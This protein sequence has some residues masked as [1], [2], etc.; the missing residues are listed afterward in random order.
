MRLAIFEDRSALQFAPLSLLRPVFELLCGQFS[1]RERLFRSIQIEEWGVLIRPALTEVYA[2]QHPAARIND[3]IWLSEG[4]T[5][6]INGRWLPSNAELEKLAQAS[7]DTVGMIGDSVAYLLLE[8]EE[9]TLLTTDAW[10]DAIQ[11]IAATRKSVVADGVEL[12]YPW[13]LVNQNHQQLLADFSFSQSANSSTGDARNLTIV[14]PPDL[15]RVSASAEIDPFVVLDTRQGP[16]VIEENATIQAFTRIEGPAYIGKGTRLFRANLKAGTT[17]GPYCRL[18][19]E[20]EES[21]IH[22]YANK[23]HDGFLGHSYICPW[24][25]L[26]AQ[27]SNSDLKNDYS[28]V[29]VP[30]MGVP[31]ETQAVKVGCFIGDHTKTGLNSLFNTGTSVGVMSMVLPTGELLPKHIPSFS[32]FW[33]GRIDCQINMSDLFQLA[34]ISMQRR[35]LSLSAGQRKLLVSLF[36][37]TRDERELAI[38]WWDQKQAS[39]PAPQSMS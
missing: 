37:E 23:Y 27:T 33:L 24:V 18:G 30:L 32:R 26:G 35:G 6:L 5:L 9:S 28:E 2:E 39:R 3:A 8:P 17:V 21:I 38:A 7:S 29:K 25:N 4:P 19:G 36:E 31:I 34:E 13:D 16:V 15:V 1:A 11:K 10:D 14:G 20:I 12:Q 22:G